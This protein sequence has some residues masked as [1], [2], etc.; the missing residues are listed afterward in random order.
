[1]R[2]RTSRRAKERSKQSLGV[3]Q[4]ARKPRMRR[5]EVQSPYLSVQLV[6]S[7]AHVRGCPLTPSKSSPYVGIGYEELGLETDQ[8]CEL[9]RR[10]L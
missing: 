9:T 7:A 10:I 3:K 2:L 4:R 1:M 5:D 8:I 6:D